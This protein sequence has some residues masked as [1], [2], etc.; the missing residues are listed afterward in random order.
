M[1]VGFALWVVAQARRRG[2]RRLYFVA[3]DGEVMLAAA[4]HVIGRLAPDLELR[5][6]YGSRKP[7]IFGATA[8]SDEFLERLGAW[9]G[10]TTRPAPCSPG[11]T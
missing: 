6:L 11:S 8:T 10:P 5:Y 3:R 4:R 7:W 1:L 2:V 9:P